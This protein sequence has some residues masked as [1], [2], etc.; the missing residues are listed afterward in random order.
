MSKGTKNRKGS[1]GKSSKGHTSPAH[2]GNGKLTETMSATE[3][4]KDIASLMDELRNATERSDKK[5]LRRMLRTR[6]H[7]G[8]LGIV[9]QRNAQRES[10]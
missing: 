3:L 1:T 8:G 2:Q 10:A 6:G 4:K 9:A 5:R 7:F